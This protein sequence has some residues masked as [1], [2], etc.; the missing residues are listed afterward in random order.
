LPNKG[1]PSFYKPRKP[2]QEFPVFEGID[3]HK[4]IYKCN[5]YFDVEHKK[6]KLAS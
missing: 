3:V 4:W 6:L 2:K 5:Q 1:T